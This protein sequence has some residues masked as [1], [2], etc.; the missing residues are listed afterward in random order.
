MNADGSGVTR[1]TNDLGRVDSDPE[2]SDEYPTWSTDGTKIAFYSDR[3]GNPEIYV[4]NSDGSE[5]TRLTYNDSAD[6]YPA[7][8]P[9][10]QTIAF[11]SSRDGGAEIYL[12][13]ADGSMQRRLPNPSSGGEPTWS[14]DGTQ[15][16]FTSTRDSY[17]EVY[18]MNID[19][20]D[21]I[22]LTNETGSGYDYS[23][24]S[25]LADWSP[26]GTTLAF[27]HSRNY[28]PN[29]VYLMNTDGTGQINLTNTDWS[30]A[31]P[32]WSSDGTKIVYQSTGESNGTYNDE[33][34][35]MNADG[36][37]QTNLTNHPADDIHPDWSP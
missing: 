34:F 3:D 25:S 28:R 17:Q 1:L 11:E 4:M 31:M 22:R 29:D 32:S 13:N 5:Q 15:I 6:R 35:V 12:M 16:A 18:V 23:F 21:Q 37:A 30:D 33:I 10:G 8:S 7:W 20:S 24:R 9:D 26:D 2:W 19:G 14:P 27:R 36:S